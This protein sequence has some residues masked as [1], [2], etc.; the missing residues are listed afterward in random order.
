MTLVLFS[1]LWDGVL[2]SSGEKR[3]VESEVLLACAA[4]CIGE[5]KVDHDAACWR[6]LWT[7]SCIYPCGS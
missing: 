5:E 4:T 6:D 3:L 2:L 7:V 1:S